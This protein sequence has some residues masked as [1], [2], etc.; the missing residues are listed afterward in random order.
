MSTLKFD[1]L[2]HQE[3]HLI[4]L[5]SYFVKLF[6]NLWLQLQITVNPGITRL[7]S[8]TLTVDYK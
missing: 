4:C 1:V 2:L 6:C 8:L 5:L 7:S 3:V